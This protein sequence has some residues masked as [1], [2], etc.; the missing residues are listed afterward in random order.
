MMRWLLLTLHLFL[1]FEIKA[2]V[3]YLEQVL[4][5]VEQHFP[6]IKV[7]QF[8]VEQ[9][10][11]NK[12]VREGAYDL[13]F[14]IDANAMPSGYYDS[15]RVATTIEQLTTLS[16]MK[17]FGAYSITD[18]EW[19]IYDGKMVTDNGGEVRVGLDLPILKDRSID[20][21]RAELKNA[22]TGINVAETD[23]QYQILEA[24]QAASAAHL[25]WVASRQELLIFEDLLKTAQK[26][27]SILKQRS[28]LGDVAKFDLLDNQRAELQRKAQVT[29]AEQK[30]YS[31][32]LNLSLYHRDKHGSPLVPKVDSCPQLSEISISPLLSPEL[33]I[34]TAIDQRPE[35]KN[36]A[37]KLEQNK[38]L[39]EL[40]ENQ[41]YPNLNLQAFSA[42]NMGEGLPENQDL[43]V[44]TGLRLTVP[45]QRSAAKGNQKQAVS[46]GQQLEQM[47]QLQI[48]QIEIEL[49]DAWQSIN[50]TKEQVSLAEAESRA[51]ID[52]VAGENIKFEHGDSNLIYLNI[53]EQ[54]AAEA[55]LREVTSRLNY[56]KSIVRYRTIS[57]ELIKRNSL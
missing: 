46:R 4:T 3:L 2:E 38:V 37:L 22:E 27:T 51:A 29:K 36:I 35:L 7:A 23:K 30:L 43:D 8:G 26:R 40:A 55:K 32:A 16:G 21:P 44:Y 48:Q 57:G 28:E 19:P 15:T 34:H 10:Q 47:R 11:A 54:T 6:R 53:R 33:L 45:L 9:A 5:E 31:S 20:Q 49:N 13:Q 56:L 41:L 42:Q 1:A 18:G 14:G 25:E 17:F 12:Q 39:Q 24:K 52:L 50:N